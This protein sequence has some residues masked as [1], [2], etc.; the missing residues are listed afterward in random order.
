VVFININNLVIAI[1][2]AFLVL[3]ERELL[4]GAQSRIGPVLIGK[5]QTVIDRVK[6]LTKGSNS[7]II[8]VLFVSFS[9][10]LLTTHGVDMVIVLSIL[11]MAF[12]AIVLGS[13]NLYSKLGRLRML[14]LVLT[15]EI[16][17]VVLL[18]SEGILVVS[19]LSF[20]FMVD[21]RRTPVDLVER[22][23]ELVSR[24]NTEFG[25][26]LFTCF[27]MGEIIILINFFILLLP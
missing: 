17:L 9:I 5:L 15:F 3:I 18:I 10:F 12:L 25:R 14:I 1:S 20:C 2:I 11:A 26:L 16:V 19:I 7:N 6:L 8:G 13:E 21:G 27:F 22:E 24:F 4:G 23:S